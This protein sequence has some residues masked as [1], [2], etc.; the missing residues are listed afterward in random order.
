MTTPAVAALKRALPQASLTYVVEEPYHRLIGG[1]PDIDEIILIPP[2]QGILSFP[3]FIRRVRREKYD[4]VIDFHGGPRASRIAWLS[5]A[6][7]KVGY[8][9][10]HKGFIYDI[11]VPR[12]R[13]GAPV[14]SVENHLNLVR[15]AG[16]EVHEPWPRLNFPAAGKEET[17]RIDKLWADRGLAGAKVVVLHVGAGNAFRDWGHQKLGGLAGR[18]AGLLGVRVILIGSALDA[19]RAEEIRKIS[20]KS[21]LS[22]AGELNLAELREVIGRAALFIGPDSGPMHIAAT[23]LTPIVALFGPTLPANFS[24]WQAR[25][26]LLEKPLDCRP[27][28]QRKCRTEDFRCLELITVDEVLKACLH[29]L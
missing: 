20:P 29:Y 17:E 23:T 5:R 9:L 2:H 21:V 15:A 8:E 26:T 7:L 19:P 22:L 24:P 18:L 28:K 11:R 3:G 4:L 12:H 25:A 27:C 14:H 10:K 13:E 6:R 1:N 16:I